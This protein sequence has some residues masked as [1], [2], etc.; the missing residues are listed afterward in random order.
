MKVTIEIEDGTLVTPADV[1]CCKSFLSGNGKV[2]DR[3]CIGEDVA[4]YIEDT[5]NYELVSNAFPDAPET[6]LPDK[7]G[8]QIPPEVVEKVLEEKP[9]WHVALWN[10]A[11]VYGYDSE[12]LGKM[13]PQQVVK[14]YLY[15]REY[16][17]KPGCADDGRNHG[18]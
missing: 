10:L 13:V 11:N 18:V 6:K 2:D 8:Y 14:D 3:F 16:D 1:F 7:A 17:P 5:T 12:T 4:E 15:L 9:Y